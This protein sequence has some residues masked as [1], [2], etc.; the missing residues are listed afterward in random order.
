MHGKRVRELNGNNKPVGSERAGDNGSLHSTAELSA[1]EH[2]FGFGDTAGGPVEAR[3]GQ[4]YD[5]IWR[6]HQHQSGELDSCRQPP[7]NLHGFFGRLGRWRAQ[8]ERERH[9]RGK[10]HRRTDLRSRIESVRE[11]FGGRR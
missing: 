2:S 9:R 1:A 10:C 3:P 11:L 8:L 7:P 6:D 4:H 5:S